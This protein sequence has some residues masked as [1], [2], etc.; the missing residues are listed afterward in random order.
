MGRWH[1]CQEAW[2]KFVETL[3]RVGFSAAP[4]SAQLLP[5][6]ALIASSGATDPRST[7]A[8]LALLVGK[9]S[10]NRLLEVP[11]ELLLM[12]RTRDV[13]GRESADG[14][15]GSCQRLTESIEVVQEELVELSRESSSLDT[16]LARFTKAL[17][18]REEFVVLDKKI[19]GPSS[20][21]E[22]LNAEAETPHAV[23]EDTDRSDPGV[24]AERGMVEGMI[25]KAQS[26][27][28]SMQTNLF[29]HGWDDGASRKVEEQKA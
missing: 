25:A 11:I 18:G 21:I 4:F 26:S 9:T 22:G 2:S 10:W 15:D 27:I 8:N 28:E 13:E 1:S 24:T 19:D 12:K 17:I 16:A 14:C 20:R 23:L 3:N 5:A 7:L 6:T 29:S